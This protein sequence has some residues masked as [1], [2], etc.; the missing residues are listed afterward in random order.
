MDV[1]RRCI[2]MENQIIEIK[3]SDKNKW[4]ILF[5]SFFALLVLILTA[6]VSYAWYEI[7][8]PV[9]KNN[10]QQSFFMVEKGNS[11]K[12]I[13]AKLRSENFIR[14]QFWFKVYV[15]AKKQGVNLQAGEY[16]LSPNLSIP[17]ILQIITGG[18]VIPNEVQITFP[19]GFTLNQIKA[20]LLE[21]GIGSAGD[22]D[23]EKIDGFQIQYKFLSDISSEKSLEGFLFPDTYRFNKDI[24]KEE[25]I[26]KFLDNF[27]K[28]LTPAWRAEIDRQKKTIYDVI[29]LA[30]IIQQEA[31]S[32]E[33]MPMISGIFWNRLK[34]GMLL[35]SDATVNYST[36][37]KV[38]QVSIDDTKIQS[39]Y[40]TYLYPGLPPT[41]ICNPG[42]AAIKAAI[43]FQQ[44]DYL[45]FL[46]PLN[47]PAVY[48]KTLE[49]HNRNKA[50][51]L[52]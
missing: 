47:S 5:I 15:L 22:F 38:R 17:E 21:N 14:S 18:K 52:K 33:E 10:S 1:A 24:K 50:K 51:Y 31:L 43:Y 29:I 12:E 42:E 9:D 11:V 13:A 16:A 2:G 8:T 28:K 39:P 3:K 34:K 20:R 23:G 26:K 35:Q 41:P 48:A 6:A 27:D 40:N 44:S 37:K 45:Y 25:I 19:E 49:E 4:F 46:H 30:S 7:Y 36:G 32:D